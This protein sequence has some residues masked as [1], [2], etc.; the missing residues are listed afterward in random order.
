MSGDGQPI[1][2]DLV[3]PF[4]E[5]VEIFE[6]FVLLGGKLLELVFHLF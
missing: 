1:E 5:V 4:E 6:L 3:V 2:Q